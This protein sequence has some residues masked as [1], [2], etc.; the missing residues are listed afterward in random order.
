MRSKSPTSW[1]SSHR[2]RTTCSSLWGSRAISAQWWIVY[3]IIVSY[4]T[5]YT[6]DVLP[7]ARMCPSHWWVFARVKLSLLLSFVIR[8]A[9]IFGAVAVLDGQGL[10]ETS[11]RERVPYARAFVLSTVCGLMPAVGIAPLTFVLKRRVSRRWKNYPTILERDSVRSLLR[12]DE[13]MWAAVLDEFR[14]AIWLNLL[15][16]TESSENRLHTI[17]IFEESKEAIMR[18]QEGQYARDGQ[19]KWLYSYVLAGDRNSQRSEAIVSVLGVRHVNRRVQQ[20]R[21]GD[22]RSEVAKAL[23]KRFQSDPSLIDGR[24]APSEWKRWIDNPDEF[25]VLC[26]QRP[27]ARE[28]RRATD[29]V[30]QLIGAERERREQGATSR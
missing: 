12:L 28:R 2:V 5:S 11:G 21:K 13:L 1:Q 17:I 16:Y 7:L 18:R 25:E 22:T 6:K 27:E 29:L 14:R 9:I 8:S 3:A 19:P 26:R 23:S 15:S 30:E 20:L 4:A 10:L 24:V